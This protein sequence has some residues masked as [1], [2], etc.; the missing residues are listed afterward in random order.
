MKL[1]MSN[2][3]GHLTAKQN[4]TADRECHVMG[5]SDCYSLWSSEVHGWQ[6]ESTAEQC[7]SVAAEK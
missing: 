2:Q 7:T 1:G 5:Q 3:L 6:A 4:S